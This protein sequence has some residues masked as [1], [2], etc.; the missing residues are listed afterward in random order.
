MEYV[1][2]RTPDCWLPKAILVFA[3]VFIAGCGDR[4]VDRYFVKLTPEHAEAAYEFQDL[5]SDF[6]IE[7]FHQFDS[8]AQGFS[9]DIPK[10]L[11]TKVEALNSV[12]RVYVDER[13]PYIP[14]NS[15]E[16]VL[17]YGEDEV[18]A[19]ILRVGGPYTGSADIS[20]IHVAVLDT[21]IDSQHPDLRVF[22]EMDIVGVSTGKYA[23]GTDPGGHGTHVAGIIGAKANG[24]GIAGVAPGVALHSVRVLDENGEGYFSDI[25][26]GLEYAYVNSDIRIVNLS[27][28]TEVVPELEMLETALGIM[29]EAGIV[30]CMSAGNEGDDTNNY[31]PTSY[32]YGIVVSAYD[33]VVQDGELQDNGFP[34]FSNYG[35]EVDISAPGKDISSTVPNGEY[36][37]LSGTSQ[38]APHV[39]GAVALLLA[40]KPHLSAIEVRDYIVSYGEQGYE[41]QTDLDGKH[42]EPLLNIQ[43]LLSNLD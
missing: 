13:K 28:N 33:V 36:D 32:N 39:A 15:N 38:A 4:T 23:G 35:K 27:L 2:H 41:G 34:A 22:A 30:V 29:E 6:D 25:L 5:A 3:S 24:S 31:A 17:E 16:F 10:Y 1:E 21:G 11:V 20:K 37:K 9:A 18:P 19:N 14:Q 12:E 40:E 8:F 42:P 7:I 26:T 43:N